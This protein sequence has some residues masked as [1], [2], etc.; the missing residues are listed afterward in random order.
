MVSFLVVACFSLSATAAAISSNIGHSTVDAEGG[1]RASR[2]SIADLDLLVSDMQEPPYKGNSWIEG[3]LSDDVRL[4]T[5]SSGWHDGSISATGNKIGGDL[6]IEASGIVLQDSLR[7]DVTDNQVGGDL[8]INVD[9]TSSAD[10][11]ILDVGN[12]WVGGSIQ[13]ALSL[14]AIG[15]LHVNV[16]DNTACDEMVIVILDNSIS[17]SLFAVV[18]GNRAFSRMDIDVISNEDTLPG[19]FYQMSV[20]INS[21]HVVKGDLEVDVNG[22]V[23]PL[24]LSLIQTML[25]E[26]S[27]NGAGGDIDVSVSDNSARLCRVEIYISEN[28]SNGRMNID[29]NGNISPLL[30]ITIEKSHS[31]GA[32]P[33]VD[34][35]SGARELSRFCMQNIPVDSD[36]DGL[37]DFYERMVG[38]DWSNE[39]TDSDGLL[40][41]WD[42][43]NG[44]MRWDSGERLG[45]IGDPSGSGQFGGIGSLIPIEAHQPNPIAADI[46]VEVDHI[47]GAEIL[48]D[49]AIALMTREFARHGIRLHVDNG[50]SPHGNH[51]GQALRFL[52]SDPEREEYLLFSGTHPGHHIPGAQNDFY[53]YKEDANVFDPLRKDIFH[54]S[55]IAPYISRMGASGVEYRDQTTGR[56]EIGGDDFV[57]AGD[58][59]DAWIEKNSPDAREEDISLSWART[60]MHELGHNLNL[61]DRSDPSDEYD[62]VMFGYSSSIKPLDY[63]E[64]SGWAQ[65]ELDAVANP[66][67]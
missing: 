49:E 3:P 30:L 35:Q 42:D 5:G 56:S 60:F 17:R 44:N 6:T 15:D 18:N 52:N 64:S 29:V 24:Q 38:T 21:N 36:G 8:T 48:P 37:S 62:T 14:N 66:G 47:E 4:G 61:D 40:D 20:S 39:D 25:I 43:R 51:G 59:V 27:S 16:Y 31:C 45:E 65:L 58:V 67:D 41:G 34:S 13:V 54:Y 63:G 10:S 57:I 46:Y 11:I 7:I 12:N 1:L 33:S 2:P 55:I 22:N 32:L 53:D 50:W 26:V 19:M 9:E 23:M 28:Y